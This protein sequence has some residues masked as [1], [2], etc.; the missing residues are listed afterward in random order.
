MA[1]LYRDR[2]ADE[3]DRKPFDREVL[4]GAAARIVAGQLD[5]PVLEVGAGPGHIGAHLAGHGV[6]VVTS[7]ASRG[8]LAQ[9]RA[10]QPRASIVLCD[11]ANLP[12]RDG[13]LAGILAFYCLIY[14]P[15]ELLGAVFAEWRRALVPGG[16]VVAAVQAGDGTIHHDHFDDRVVDLTVVLRD[17]D[18]VARRLV[19]A[20]FAVEQQVVR[21]PYADEGTHRMYVLARAQ[22]C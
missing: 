16:L 15:P 9:A 12:A 1:D 21:A 3:L 8:Q 2:F 22:P 20:G 17:P 10:L 14:T 11:L 13:S 18:D 4:A 6:P 19:D 7:D 5:A